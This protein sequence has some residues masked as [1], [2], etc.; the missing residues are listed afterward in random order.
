MIARVGEWQRSS[1]SA[2][3]F[4]Q[5][6][7]IS[8]STFQYWIRK[9]RETSRISDDTP[10]FIEIRSSGFPKPL[11]ETKSQREN[12]ANPQIVL[13]FPSGLCLKIFA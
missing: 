1:I 10:G 5:G 13:T 12:W 3:A 8:K 4:A 9:V 6:L 7:G 2:G 11:A